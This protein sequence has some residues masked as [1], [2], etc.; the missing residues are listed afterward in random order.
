VAGVADEAAGA[1]AASDAIAAGTTN[2]TATLDTISGST[3][4]TVNNP[5]SL[6]VSG[7]PLLM[8]LDFSMQGGSAFLGS[9]NLLIT[10]NSMTQT[11]TDVQAALPGGWSDVLQDASNCA[12]LA[13]G[14]TCTLKFTLTT[15][16]IHAAE[17]VQI[18]GTNTNSVSATLGVNR[19]WVTN[20]TVN[21]VLPDP[22]HNAIYIGGTF[23]YVGPNTG[24]GVPIGSTSGAALTSF[25]RVNGTINAAIPDGVGGWYIGGTFTRVGGITRNNI[26]H[27]LSDYT[28]D[29]NFNPNANGIVRALAIN[30]S[31]VY[32]GGDFLTIGG[33][34]R[35]RLAALCIT[36]NC[37]G[38]N[39][40]A[41]NATTWNPT[42][43]GTV[44]ALA[45]NGNTVYAGGFFTT[46][47]G[48]LPRNY[49]AAAII[50]LMWIGATW[51]IWRWLAD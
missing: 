23:T 22:A 25:P 33:Q 24:N 1:G 11:A 2:I 30:G 15:N 41:G 21:A 35:N 26:A 13:P 42:A 47:N 29:P 50:I 3:S 20:G 14:A 32:A 48:G 10:N 12:S 36:A 31:T 38:N 51:L 18:S 6:S 4:L 44:F 5:A 43:N 45:I 9:A 16:T 46:I 19:P 34:S 49:I 40:A 7:S 28:V 27:I 37:D 39:T 17:V 8:T